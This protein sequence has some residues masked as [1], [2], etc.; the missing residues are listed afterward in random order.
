MDLSGMPGFIV[1]HGAALATGVAALSTIGLHVPVRG[2]ALRDRWRGPR[3]S[4]SVGVRVTASARDVL[5]AADLVDVVAEC[6][7][8]VDVVE[9]HR[10]RPTATGEIAHRYRGFTDQFGVAEREWTSILVGGPAAAGDD[11]ANVNVNANSGGSFDSYDS[12]RLTFLIHRLGL[13]GLRVRPLAVE[14]FDAVA[15]AD[16]IRLL[17]RAP[18]RDH[19]RRPH[20][21]FTRAGDVDVPAAPAQLVG[22][23]RDGGPVTVSLPSIGRL[24]V[25]A[26][27][28]ARLPELLLP[29]LITGARVGIRTHRPHVFR[30]LLD[31]GAVLVTAAGDTTLD[32]LVRDGRHPVTVP[33][34][35]IHEPAV[36]TLDDG[37]RPTRGTATPTA[38]P[39]LTIGPHAWTLTAGDEETPVRPVPLMA[40]R[41]ER[42][43][44]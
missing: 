19:V 4:V 27:E 38:A 36:I 37:P 5:C 13:L 3:T 35:A 25:A 17:A 22:V 8:P 1:D 24:D 33:S 16:P 30:T 28:L 11:N 18:G 14:E 9:V 12:V 41:G 44:S 31:H 40:E 26:P 34:P 2:V 10:R 21:W 29:T 43:P 20:L 23:G 15:A 7:V 6:P 39:L 32:V 42:A